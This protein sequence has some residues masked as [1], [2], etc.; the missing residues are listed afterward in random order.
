MGSLTPR[1]AAIC[2]NEARVEKAALR[3]LQT[4]RSGVHGAPAIDRLAK[5]ALRFDAQ[6]GRVTPRRMRWTRFYFRL[7]RRRS[8]YSRPR[9]VRARLARLASP[10]GPA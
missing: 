6:C 7:L 9:L 5:A 8:L 3:A 4:A 1:L 10:S 2:V